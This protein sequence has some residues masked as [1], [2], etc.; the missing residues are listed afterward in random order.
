MHCSGCGKDVPFGGSVC[1]FCQRD[2]SSDQAATIATGIGMVIGGIIGSLISGFGGMIVG[3][4][5]LGV[6]A[7]MIA[8]S[9][10]NHSAKKPPRVRVELFVPADRAMLRPAPDTAAAPTGVTTT[11]VEER[12]R[13]LDRLKSEGLLSD[14]EHQASAAP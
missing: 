11:S 13:R 6:A 4:L 8:M 12:L 5:V 7:A 1:L 14:D 3:G 2:K 10:K 9:G